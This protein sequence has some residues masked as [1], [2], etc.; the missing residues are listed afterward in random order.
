[1]ASSSE[2]SNNHSVII[3]KAKHSIAWVASTQTRKQ[4]KYRYNAPLHI[5]GKF[6]TSHVV[7]D[8]AKKH[9][10]KS[11]RVR[12]GDKVRVM[13]GQF[14]NR[15]GKV[16]RV[17]V[18]TSKVFINKIDFLKKDGATRVAYPVD[19]SNLM[20]VEFDTSDK[21]RNQKLKKETK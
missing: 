9:G 17:D 16:E 14:K 7:K 12:V 11:M 1:V 2:G 4:R 13:R 6:L 15:E 20:I 3:M 21:R 5:K 8:L 19:A 10:T 18:K